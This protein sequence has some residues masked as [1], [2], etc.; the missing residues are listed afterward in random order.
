MKFNKKITVVSL[1]TVLGLGLVGSIT[2]AVAWYQYSTRTTSSIIGTSTGNGGTL[3]IRKDGAENWARDL[4]T[5][6]VAG[7]FAGNF[8]PMTFGGAAKDAALPEDA[9][10]QP[11]Y[12]QEAMSSWEAAAA[13]TDYLQYTIE[14]Q[15]LQLNGN[16]YERSAENVYL[17]DLVIKDHTS[18]NP[19]ISDA[20][21]IHLDVAQK[22]GENTTHTYYLISKDGADLNVYGS[23]DLNGDKAADTVGGYEWE[24]GRTR[25]LVYGDWEMIAN[26]DYDSENPESPAQILS[27]KK[28]T[29]YASSALLASI[30]AAGEITSGDPIAKTPAAASD[31]TKITITIWNEGWQKFDGD[32]TLADAMWDPAKRNNAE[33]D[34]GFRFDVDIDAFKE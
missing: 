1:S 30:N 10:K 21:R 32:T 22:V 23:L 13:G 27:G 2:G 14:L 9:Y 17:T 24:A 3:Q 11:K 29:S 34:I 18:G 7:S 28:Q 4:V 12:G 6:D 8:Q 19:D 25:E 20:V 33:F 26:P 31:Y 5:S 16:A 15:A